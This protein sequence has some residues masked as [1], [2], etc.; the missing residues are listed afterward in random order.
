MR[1][2]TTATL[3]F[4]GMPYDRVDALLAGSVPA[5]AVWRWMRER[6][7]FEGVLAPPAYDSVVHV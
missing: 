3:K 1:A 5:A 2:L 4:G 7:L 6:D